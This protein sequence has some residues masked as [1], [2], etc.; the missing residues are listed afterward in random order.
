MSAPEDQVVPGHP[1]D[2]STPFVAA[3][4]LKDGKR[5]LLL[6]ASGSVATIKLPNIIQALST[7]EALSIRI[8]LTK[9]A[10]NFLAGQSA[11]QPTLDSLRAIANVDGIYQDEDEWKHPW[12]RG[13][14]E[15]EPSLEKK[16]IIVAPAM[17]T[18]MWRHPITKRQIKVL[19][20]DWGVQG[21][22]LGWFEVLKPI[23]KELACGDVGDGAM[24]DW[25]ELV[26]VIKRRLAVNV[27]H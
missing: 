2:S 16:R 22:L 10:E 6:A 7:C 3:D 1:S 17:N 25:N 27:G 11:E 24:Q 19:E 23:E 20:E 14:G 26:A 5:H 21:D 12:T 8:L 13:G 9:S 15:I 4:H 18:A